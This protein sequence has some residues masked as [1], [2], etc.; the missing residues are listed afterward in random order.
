MATKQRNTENWILTIQIFANKQVVCSGQSLLTTP[1]ILYSTLDGK[2]KPIVKETLTQAEAW[3]LTTIYGNNVERWCRAL[4]CTAQLHSDD[5]IWIDA[6]IVAR[7]MIEYYLLVT[8]PER[9]IMVVLL[10]G[11]IFCWVIFQS[12]DRIWNLCEK[13]DLENMQKKPPIAI[14]IKLSCSLVIM[15]MLVAYCFVF[16]LWQQLLLNH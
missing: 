15:H 4:D 11:K 12:I 9:Y 3:F 5:D 13:F 14:T 6:M 10:K 1:S 7:C 16:K 2:S 8:S